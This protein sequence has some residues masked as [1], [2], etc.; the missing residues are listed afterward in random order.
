MKNTDV[1]R[2]GSNHEYRLGASE[3]KP[4]LLSG[5]TE[6]YNS[7]RS[8]VQFMS[9][10]GAMAPSQGDVTQL[11]IAWSNGD[12]TALDKLMPLVHEDLRRRARQYLSGQRPG[13]T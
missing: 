8:V 2:T 5:S 9:W 1:I 12:Q 6:R 3:A 4:P 13:H 7:G 10:R 11:L